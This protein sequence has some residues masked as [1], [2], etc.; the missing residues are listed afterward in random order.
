PCQREVG[1]PG[2]D[3]PGDRG[4]PGREPPEEGIGGEES[5]VEGKLAAVDQG[6]QEV[7]QRLPAIA[8]VV[9]QILADPGDL[10]L[11][12]SPRQGGQVELLG[13]LLPVPGGTQE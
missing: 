1:E 5:V 3:D 7:G 6:P 8:L 12:G 10:V 2:S 13:D 9:E 11:A 4:K